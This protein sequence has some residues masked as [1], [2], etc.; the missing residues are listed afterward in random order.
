[1]KGKI[2]MTVEVSTQ[3]KKPTKVSLENDEFVAMVNNR[4]KSLEF[5]Y[6]QKNKTF[7][8]PAK[9]H[10]QFETQVANDI[11]RKYKVKGTKAGNIAKCKDSQKRKLFNELKN[12]LEAIEFIGDDDQIYICKAMCKLANPKELEII[13]SRQDSK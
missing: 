9:I 10:R 2:V 1:M 11:A 7:E 12:G 13:A 8:I 4:V 6:A 3:S 5:D